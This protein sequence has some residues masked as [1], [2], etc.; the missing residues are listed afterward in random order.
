MAG[1]N[2]KGKLCF[3]RAILL[4]PNHT[5]ALAYIAYVRPSKLPTAKEDFNNI[6]RAM[7]LNPFYPV[8]YSLAYGYS[9]IYA[10]NF[11]DAINVLEK[12]NDEYFDKH[13]YLTLSYA[14]LGNY[15]YMNS[16]R[17]HLLTI[18]PKLSTDYL[19]VADSICEPRALALLR[20]CASVAGL[21]E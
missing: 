3:K 10:E 1:E 14:A 5:D 4:G 8:W 13:L 2:Q 16:H 7:K 19:I 18:Q 20:R 21:P 6:E 9:A 15:E 17:A 12:I 11:L